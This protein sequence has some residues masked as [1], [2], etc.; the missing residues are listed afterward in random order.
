MSVERPY[1]KG[2]ITFVCDGDSCTETFE[3]GTHVFTQ[4]LEIA[5]EDGMRV[6]KVGD[7]WVHL[8]RVCAR[9]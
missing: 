6:R 1:A 5:K 4:A 7:D 2:K 8:C 3:T 9:D